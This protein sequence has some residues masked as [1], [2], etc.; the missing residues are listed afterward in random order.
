MLPIFLVI[1]VNDLK[2]EGT[3]KMKIKKVISRVQE[4]QKPCIWETT[5]ITIAKAVLAQERGFL[6]RRR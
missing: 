6:W 3:V 1:G 5:S 4:D 2:A